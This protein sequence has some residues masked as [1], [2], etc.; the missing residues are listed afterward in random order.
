[1]YHVPTLGDCAF[2]CGEQSTKATIR[3]LFDSTLAPQQCNAPYIASQTPC[4]SADREYSELYS[5]QETCK[6]FLHD[7]LAM[8]QTLSLQVHIIPI[9]PHC[10]DLRVCTSFCLNVRRLTSR[11]ASS[12]LCV[13]LRALCLGQELHSS[14]FVYFQQIPVK[15]H[16]PTQSDRKPSQHIL[17]RSGIT[18]SWIATCTE[19]NDAIKRRV[20]AVPSVS[21]HLTQQWNRLQETGYNLSLSLSL[22]SRL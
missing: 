22:S 1:M 7:V 19:K 5:Q 8:A 13:R 16:G 15:G 11:K 18:T 4:N 3:N 20:A 10:I 2:P 17:Y 6:L 12:R 9:V 21:R 14:S